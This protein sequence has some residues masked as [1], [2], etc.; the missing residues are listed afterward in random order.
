MEL[1]DEQLEDAQRV[2]GSQR[3]GG[4]R[5]EQDFAQAIPQERAFRH[6]NRQHRKAFGDTV[7]GALAQLVTMQGYL[8]KD[9]QDRIAVDVGGR[10]IEV[11]TAVFEEEIGAGYWS[12]FAA[13]LLVERTPCGG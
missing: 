3:M 7:F 13:K 1:G 5:T 10:F 4:I 9:A 8:A 12:A 2:H 11:E 6:L